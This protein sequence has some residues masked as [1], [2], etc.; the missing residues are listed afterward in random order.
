MMRLQAEI[1]LAFL[2]ISHDIAVVERI[3][4]YK[5]APRRFRQVAPGHLVQEI[6]V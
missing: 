2:F 5:R 6:S 4:H 3:S 1:G